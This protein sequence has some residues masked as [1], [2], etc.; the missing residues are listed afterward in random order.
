M[1]KSSPISGLGIEGG[2]SIPINNKRI[3]SQTPN[4]VKPAIINASLTIFGLL[5]VND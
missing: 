3:R 4:E 1:L 2:G 5:L